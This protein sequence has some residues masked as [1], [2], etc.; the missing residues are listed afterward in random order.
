MTIGLKFVTLVMAVTSLI[1][2]G[3]L[4]ATA[5]SIPVTAQKSSDSLIGDDVT[6]S[7]QS[8]KM[9]LREATKNIQTGNSQAALTE[10]NMTHQAITLAGLKWNAT[11]MCSN[12]RNEPYCVAP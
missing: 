1:V 8:A 2:S 5:V 11:V 6:S 3:I 7:L 12:I 4:V 9:H 10:I